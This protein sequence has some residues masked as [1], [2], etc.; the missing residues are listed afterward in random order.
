M[1][2]NV[3]FDPP[4]D[5]FSEMYIFVTGV[6]FFLVPLGAVSDEA[7]KNRIVAA[8]KEYIRGK[9]THWWIREEV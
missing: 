7:E 1:T 8:E 6:Q 4:Q 3:H 2:N 5:G 9:R